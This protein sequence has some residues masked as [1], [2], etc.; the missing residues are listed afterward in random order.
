MAS[1]HT[2]TVDYRARL[3]LV[4]WIDSV[5]AISFDDVVQLS[6]ALAGRLGQ[7]SL[8]LGDADG[9]EAQF[10]RFQEL[11]ARA[12]QEL[13]INETFY[14][15]RTRR[16]V[17]QALEQARLQRRRVRIYYGDPVSGLDSC[18]P[19]QVGYVGRRGEQLQWP[20]L[21]SA[22]G[23]CTGTRIHSASLV[24]VESLSEYVD[25]YRHERYHLPPIDFIPLLDGQAR[26][27]V[28]GVA[29]DFADDVQA[30]RWLKSI[31]ACAHQIEQVC[32]AG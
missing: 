3:Y 19:P 7:P 4:R 22:A 12:A 11:L 14:H 2:L 27:L 32:H 17:R 9:S 5:E 25:L 21:S 13:P 28:G 16:A 23:L 6:N 18:L 26:L 24:R 31:G 8:A 20:I 15:P 30:R 1:K 29:N 10:E